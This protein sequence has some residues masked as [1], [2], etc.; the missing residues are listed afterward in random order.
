MSRTNIFIQM[1]ETRLFAQLTYFSRVYNHNAATMLQTFMLEVSLL[2]T[3]YDE[4]KKE[5]KM[6][7]GGQGEQKK[8]VE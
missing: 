7:E 3:D 5:M 6:D 8:R 2:G 1:L 4:E